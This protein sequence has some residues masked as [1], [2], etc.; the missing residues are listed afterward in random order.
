[1]WQMLFI[2]KHIRIFLQSGFATGVALLQ[3]AYNSRLVLEIC[4]FR[5]IS[6]STEMNWHQTQ[7]SSDFI[8]VCH[9]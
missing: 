8:T 3:S 6:D 7:I 5:V 1:M 9:N 4:R 2:Y